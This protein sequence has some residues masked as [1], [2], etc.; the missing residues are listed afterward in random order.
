MD[1]LFRNSDWQ[2]ELPQQVIDQPPEHPVPDQ[3][4][5]NLSFHLESR[6]ERVNP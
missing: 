6:R 3:Q 5:S 1:T 2:V 4:Q